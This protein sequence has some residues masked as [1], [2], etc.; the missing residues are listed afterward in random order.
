MNETNVVSEVVTD[1][2]VVSRVVTS[3]KRSLQL[4]PLARP[5]R[6]KADRLKI[7]GGPAASDDKLL[8]RRACRPHHLGV[9]FTGVGPM[10]ALGPVKYDQLPTGMN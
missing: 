7:T 8:R 1:D 9:L 2:A 6:E 5:R 3:A 4:H 10:V